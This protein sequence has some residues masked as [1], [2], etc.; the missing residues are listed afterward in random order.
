MG[1]RVADE[2]VGHRLDSY[3]AFRL[4]FHSRSRWKQL[5]GDGQILLNGAQA[6]GSTKIKLGD[7]LFLVPTEEPEVN[8]HIEQLYH[9]DGVMAVYKPAPLPMHENGKY[10]RNTLAH[11]VREKFGPQWGHV[12]R[13][14]LETSGIVLFGDSDSML[15]SL[16]ELFSQQKIKKEYLLIVN[17]VPEED[18]WTVDAPIGDLVESEIRIKKW[19]NCD[20]QYA[21]TDFETLE[22]GKRF[23]VLRARPKTGRTNQIRIHAA[24]SGHLIV[25][26]KLY[27]PEERVFLS[28]YEG[29]NIEWVHEKTGFSRLCLHAASLKFLHPKNGTPINIEIPLSDDLKGLWQKIKNLS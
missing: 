23:A 13:L 12:H 22:R 11:L 27:H 8:C 20:G 5:L 3:L 19:I 2:F 10:F 4:P 16:S 14:D 28:Y 7:E 21:E 1:G 9:S 18:S 6:K 17:R 26:D 15:H 29:K 25:G 24:H